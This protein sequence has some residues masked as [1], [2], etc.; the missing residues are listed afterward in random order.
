[1]AIANPPWVTDVEHV[2]DNTCSLPEPTT[3]WI[4]CS[5]GVDSCVLLKVVAE[6]ARQRSNVQLN[7]IH[8][9]HQLSANAIAWQQHV[10][11]LAKYYKLNCISK[12]VTIDNKNRHSLESQAREE[13]YQAIFDVVNDDDIIL[14]GQH[15][16]DQVETVFLRLLRG[17]GPKGLSAMKQVSTRVH[18]AKTV[19]LVRPL[20]AVSRQE[21]EAYANNHDLVWVN[22]E[23]NADLSFD[24]N[25]LRQQWFAS[26]KQQ[27]PQRWPGMQKAVLRSAVL[28][29]QQQVAL[30]LLLSEKLATVTTSKNVLSKRAL[31][32]LDTRVRPE[33]LRYWLS[34]LTAQMPSSAVLSEL[35]KA[36]VSDQ[37]RSPLIKWHEHEIR[38]H[39]DRVV[40]LASGF[41]PNIIDTR[42]TNDK[43]I[44][45]QDWQGQQ[46]YLNLDIQ[47]HHSQLVLSQCSD[48]YTTELEALSAKIEFDAVCDLRVKSNVAKQLFATNLNGK[49]RP[50]KKWFK[51]WKTPTWYRDDIVGVFA[52]EHLLAVIESGNIRLN[53]QT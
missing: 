10:E 40:Y 51:D 36:L 50:L 33:L 47:N 9:N 24:R 1:M 42:L 14:L 6:W 4:A 15:L 22:D 13:R 28:A 2:L 25:M 53:R 12:S 41:H 17:S 31:L 16:D 7:V 27:W 5:G 43:A 8:I 49:P 46:W 20:L 30:E 29:E 18:G 3:L 26:A 19:S 38:I 32:T 11:K 45:L 34:E 44:A 52:G 39:A 35:C 23:S 21:I 37:D 48:V